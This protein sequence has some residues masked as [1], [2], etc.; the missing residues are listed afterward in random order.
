MIP[1]VSTACLYPDNTEK[2][3]DT[4]I[5]LGVRTVEIFFNTFSEL[6]PD[7][8]GELKRR[9]DAGGVRVLSLHPFTCG[10]EP[11]LF[12]TGYDRRFQD[13]RD[14]YKQYYE[15]ANTLGA[16]IVVFHGGVAG[17]DVQ[18]V[19]YF[20]R[21]GKL[22]D[23]AKSQ[24][25]DLCHENVSRCVGNNIDFFKQMKVALPHAK[26]VF[27]VKQ[28]V[29][30]DE[31]VVEFVKYLGENIAHVH[32]NDHNSMHSCLPLGK[33]TFNIPNFLQQLRSY[34]FCGGVTVELYRENF[35]ENV[36]LYE[37]YQLLFRYLSTVS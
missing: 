4:L 8:I 6:T 26:Y 23:D 36:E 5:D 30:S 37:C 9:T 14:L 11:M 19:D 16:S 34:G 17:V 20:G 32:I 25:I 13:G 18:K 27:D 28:A 33:G 10:L 31:D 7:F 29:R 15:A 2:A 12:F 21:F 24:G 35:G 3:L 22:I 1:A